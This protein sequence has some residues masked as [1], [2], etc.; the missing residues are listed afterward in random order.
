MKGK[1]IAAA[2]AAVLLLMGIAFA[3]QQSGTEDKEHNKLKHRCVIHLEELDALKNLKINIKGLDFLKDLELDLE[4]LEALKDLQDLND[5]YFDPDEFD[6]DFDM[7][8]FDW[9]STD[10]P[11]P[12]RTPVPLD[13]DNRAPAE[14]EGRSCHHSNPQYPFH[15]LIS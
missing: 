11:R 6:F 12:V 5:L 7:D 9:G 1:Q 10:H 2:V 15:C 8:D 14:P 13:R 4:R 3:V